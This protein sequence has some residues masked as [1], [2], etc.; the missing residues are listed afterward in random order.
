[1]KGVFDKPYKIIHYPRRVLKEIQLLRL[2]IVELTIELKKIGSAFDE[3][4]KDI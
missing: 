4:K 1:M 3:L 2:A